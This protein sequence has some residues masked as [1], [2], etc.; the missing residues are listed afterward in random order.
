MNINRNNVDG[1]KSDIEQSVDFYNQWF[2]RF[3]PD[4]CA[5]LT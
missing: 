5:S 1:W 3:A 2:L 4:D